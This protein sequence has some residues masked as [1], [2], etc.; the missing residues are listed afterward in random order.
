[1]TS[2]DRTHA[3]RWPVVAI[4]RTELD[5]SGRMDGHAV[6]VSSNT[7]VTG[8]RL[9]LS[10]AKAPKLLPWLRVRIGET[11][12][13]ATVTGYSHT[14]RLVALS[15]RG[16]QGKPAEWRPSRTLRLGESIS[17]VAAMGEDLRATDGEIVGL[18]LT[19]DGAPYERH[20]EIETSVSAWPDSA[21]AGLF[22]VRGNIIGVCAETTPDDRL[23]AAPAD[24]FAVGT[25]KHL[26]RALLGNGVFRDAIYELRRLVQKPGGAEDPE[27]WC[28]LAVGYEALGRGQ[29]RRT[30]LRRACTLDDQNAWAAHALGTTLLSPPAERGEARRFL[31]RAAALEPWNDRYKMRE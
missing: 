9:A 25:E 26:A 14:W 13:A 17:V 20:Y 24:R 18:R 21:G 29:D 8:H 2:L 5:G 7:L 30:A 4:Q 10:S 6:F 22:D 15:A 3:M 23:V 27:L 28:M 31:Q 1:M 19:N 11:D 16:L 12:L